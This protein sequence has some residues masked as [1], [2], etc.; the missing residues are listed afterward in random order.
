MKIKKLA[1]ALIISC[2]AFSVE[3]QEAKTNAGKSSEK[4]I[5]AYC[6]DFNWA[7]TGR[8]R[9]PFAKPGAWAG[10]DPAQHVAWQ[11]VDGA[12]A[13]RLVEHGEDRQGAEH[14]LK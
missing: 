5:K 7:A 11:Q 3:A 6:L 8:R 10:A 4:E 12:G 13:C 9:K 1:L 2:L 14:A